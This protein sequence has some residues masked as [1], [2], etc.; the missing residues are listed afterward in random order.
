MVFLSIISKSSSYTS[1][2]AASRV[3]MKKALTLYNLLLAKKELQLSYQK[4]FKP[5]QT[6]KGLVPCHSN[7]HDNNFY[8]FSSPS[9]R[10]IVFSHFSTNTESGNEEESRSVPFVAFSFYKFIAIPDSLI[11]NIV[12]KLRESL[13]K[14]SVK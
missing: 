13:N 8:V 12:Y 9:I 1:N 3:W 7:N 4:V 14:L 2:S 10:G 5:P 11:D 6:F